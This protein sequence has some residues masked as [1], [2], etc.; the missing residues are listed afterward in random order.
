MIMRG[1]TRLDQYFPI[2]IQN[3]VRFNAQDWDMIRT[4]DL[5]NKGFGVLVTLDTMCD[6]IRYCYRLIGMKA[7]W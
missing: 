6:M 4:N 7:F 2:D 1:G 5:A 3:D